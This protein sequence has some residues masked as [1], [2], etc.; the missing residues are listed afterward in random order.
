MA[1][2]HAVAEAAQ[3][4]QA[5][6][7]EPV[8]RPGSHH[9]HLPRADYGGVEAVGGRPPA[10]GEVEGAE[11]GAG[12]VLHAAARVGRG[13]GL[14]AVEG[15]V[16]DGDGGEGDDAAEDDAGER[17]GGEGGGGE[18]GGGE[19]GRVEVVEEGVAKVAG[20]GAGEEEVCPRAAL[21]AGRAEEAAEVGAGGEWGSTAWEGCG[22]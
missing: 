17:R 1:E 11:E 6:A 19:P 8:V 4:S 13:E 14:V 15:D 2:V 20:V 10:A 9:T 16:A 7:R 3:G 5:G 12:G 22:C 21:D 18:L